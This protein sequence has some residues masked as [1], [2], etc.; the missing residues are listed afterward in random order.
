MKLE[1]LL[2][3]WYQNFTRKEP[4]VQEANDAEGVPSL[5][6]D[7]CIRGVYVSAPGHCDVGDGLECNHWV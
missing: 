3:I 7:Q 5:V 4:V 6:A 2:V 1:M